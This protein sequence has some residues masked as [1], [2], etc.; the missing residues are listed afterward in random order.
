MRKCNDEIY[1]LAKDQGL[2][3]KFIKKK[4]KIL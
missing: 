1:Q 4:K 3:K 2:V